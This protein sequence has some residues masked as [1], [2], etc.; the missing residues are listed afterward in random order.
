[1]YVRVAHKRTRSICN[2]KSGR[3]PFR[4]FLIGRAVRRDH[5]TRRCRSCLSERR[6]PDT[7]RTQSFT[8]DRI[9]HEF[10]QDRE[11]TLAC[12]LFRL[13]DGVAHA[14]AYSEMFSYNDSH[15]GR[16]FLTL[17][18]KVNGQKIHFLFHCFTICSS[19]AT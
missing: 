2:I 8:D 4:A 15:S 11:R 7:L 17:C 1:L 10:A 12:E 18:Y 16:M 9:V 3:A 14:E 19:T 13:G 5:D 6:F